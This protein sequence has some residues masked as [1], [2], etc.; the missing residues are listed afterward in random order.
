MEPRPQQRLA[1]ERMSAMRSARPL[2]WFALPERFYGKLEQILDGWR[3][4][5]LVD[6]L[7][8]RFYTG[9]SAREAMLPASTYFR[10]LMI[11]LFEGIESV[12]AMA[13]R[14]RDSVVLRRFL[15][16]GRAAAAPDLI[17]VARTRLQI[18]AAIHDEVFQWLLTALNDC[19]VDDR[20]EEAGVRV[21]APP[22]WMRARRY[23][24]FLR[25]FHSSTEAGVEAAR[26]CGDEGRHAKP[27]R[28]TDPRDHPAAD[29]TVR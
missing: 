9:S 23:S 3:F 5:H 18:D 4:D 12:E 7:C 16:S 19:L 17:Q 26:A 1:M 25:H 21:A 6:G 2:P 24:D 15:G 22:R 14:T 10:L 11:G 27:R 29:H 20:S 28:A 13:W 8:S